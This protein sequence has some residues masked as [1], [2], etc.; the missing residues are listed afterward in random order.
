MAS[1][2]TVEIAKRVDA[3]ANCFIKRNNITR[4]LQLPKTQE[5]EQPE[6]LSL[7]QLVDPSADLDDEG[8][9]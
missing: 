2:P 1:G 9:F 6:G 3:L 7:R 8:L 4:Q 5:H